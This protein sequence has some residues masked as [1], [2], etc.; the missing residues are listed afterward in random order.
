M[1]KTLMIMVVLACGFG[2][3]RAQQIDVTRLD[4]I[5]AV[6]SFAKT[7]KG[8]T[9]NCADNSQVQLLVLAPDL[10]RVRA[11]FANPIPMR[12]HSWAIAKDIWTTT[13]GMSL[14]RHRQSRSALL[15]S[16]PLCANRL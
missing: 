6:T 7:E 13:H 9:I 15:K 14:R 11:S 5:G 3:S 8:I 1:N 12:D 2:V 16:K 10:I 4:K